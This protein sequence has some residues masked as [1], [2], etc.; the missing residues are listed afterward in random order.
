MVRDGSGMDEAFIRERLF[1]PF[2]STKGTQGMG[3][4]AYQI[5]ETVRAMGGEVRIESEPDQ[6]TKVTLEFH[7]AGGEKV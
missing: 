2:D 5:R 1:K 7:Q 3:I 4:G 6:G